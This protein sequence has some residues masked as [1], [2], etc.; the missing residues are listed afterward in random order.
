MDTREILAKRTAE[1]GNTLRYMRKEKVITMVS[2][3][4][5]KCKLAEIRKFRQGLDH[6]LR[7]LVRT[8]NLF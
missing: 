2:T 7:G 5:T 3:N 6:G 1:P 4:R 8:W